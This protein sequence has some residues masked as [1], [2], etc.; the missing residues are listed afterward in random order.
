[1]KE[2]IIK[3]L[4]L[5]LTGD[6]TSPID[7]NIHKENLKFIFSRSYQ[8]RKDVKREYWRNYASFEDANIAKERTIEILNV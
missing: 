5:F 4:S 8:S 2:H 3:N 7:K 6:V 1:M